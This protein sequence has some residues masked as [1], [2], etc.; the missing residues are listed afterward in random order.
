MSTETSKLTDEEKRRFA[1]VAR[2][3]PVQCKHV[4]QRVSSL[5]DYFEAI[6]GIVMG[7]N[8][9]WFRGHP[10]ANR[11]L[12]PAALRPKTLAQR[13]AALNL[14]LDFRRIA[15]ARLPR[16]PD[17][18][19][20]FKWAQLAQ[21]YGLPTRLLDWT[22]SAAAPQGHLGHPHPPATRGEDPSARPVQPRRRQ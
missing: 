21:H 12:T 14:I 20:D 3:C 1:E 19:D 16:L 8:T 17:A 22:E 5:A 13:E 10:E 6:G 11:S 4:H 2:A 7:E 18:E 15:E 9:F